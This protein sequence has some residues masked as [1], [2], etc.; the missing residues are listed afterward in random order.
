V[1]RS[2]VS[3]VKDAALKKAVMSFLRPRVEPYGE[4]LDLQLDTTA[5]C[6]S[7]EVQLKGELVPLRIFEAHYRLEQSGDQTELIFYGIKASREWVQRLLDDNFPQIS[8]K[9]PE[10]LRLLIG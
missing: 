4:I 1:N 7:A 3:R 6:L 2:L 10:A 9:I 5:K 8:V